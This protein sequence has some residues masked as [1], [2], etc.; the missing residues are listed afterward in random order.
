MRGARKLS[1]EEVDLL[2][3]SFAGRLGIRNRAFFMFGLNTGFRVTELLSLKIGDVLESSGQIKD[4]VMISRRFMKGKKASR[5]VVINPGA[6]KALHPLLI[7]LR[8]SGV[9]HRDD[10]IFR[11]SGRGNKAITREHA[12]RIIHNAAMLANLTGQVSTHSMRKTFA[13]AV[14]SRLLAR[15]SEGEAV[16]AFRLTSKAL[17]HMSIDSTDK[18]LEINGEVVDDVILEAWM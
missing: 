14:Y 7:I 3:R 6:K 1:K 9:T 2:K 4:Y 17:G 8:E 15:V 11:S 12:W 10:Y 16:D 18:Y 13:G 5:S